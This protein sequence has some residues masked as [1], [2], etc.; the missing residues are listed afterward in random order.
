MRRVLLCILDGW[1]ERTLDHNNGL[2]V[3]KNWQRLLKT[4][5]HTFLNASE[6]Y[7]GLPDGQMGNSEVGHMT[8]GLGRVMVQDLPRIN[9]AIDD[10]T[11][12]NLDVFSEFVKKTKAGSNCCHVMGLFSAGGVHSHENHFLHVVEILENEGITV[13]VHPILDGRDTPPNSAEGSLKRIEGYLGDTV[14]PGTISGRYFT[15]DRDNRWDRTKKAYDAF[16]YSKGTHHK[17]FLDAL[18]AAYTA[19]ITDEFV[20]PSSIGDYT[21]IN[22]SDSFFFINFRGDRARQWLSALTLPD[23]SQFPV[24]HPAFSSVM[25]MTDY[26]KE[27]SPYHLTLFP[28]IPLTEGL[29]EIVSNLDLQQLRIAETEKYAHVT[30]FFN[31]GQEEPFEG[32][33]RI[34]VPSPDVATYDLKPEMSASQVTE[35]VL[36]ALHEK[37]HHL[38]VVNYANPDMVGHTGV[39]LA[40]EK[41][42]DTVDEILAKL[43]TEALKNDWLLIVT[44]DHGNVEQIVDETGQPHTAHTCNLVPFLV[45]NGDAHLKLRDTGTLADIAPTLL[46]WLDLP[47]PSVMSGRALPTTCS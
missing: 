38:I 23:F 26:S 7:V 43:E 14:K 10:G 3:A 29:G 16:A 22:P 32:E 24:D 11:F 20:V 31:G 39:R 21:G 13:I 2:L 5:P 1:G 15:M 33:D 42:I 18:N 45:I 35:H 19:N 6:S 36:S 40:I 9:K 44:A 37:K 8:I 30:Y 46:T 12:Q 27:L 47:V 4:Y 28:K 41:A 34:L 17:T 25:T